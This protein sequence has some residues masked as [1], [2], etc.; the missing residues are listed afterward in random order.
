MNNW[1]RNEIIIKGPAD[2]L[3]LFLNEKL[4]FQKFHPRPDDEEYTDWNII[5]WGC[6][7]EPESIEIRLDGD[8]IKATFDTAWMPPTAF[9]TY[10]TEFYTSIKI[11]N[12]YMD[13]IC[14]FMGYSVSENGITCNESINPFDYSF[15][16]LREFAKTNL[17]YEPSIYE[18]MIHLSSDCFSICTCLNDEQKDDTYLNAHVIVDI[19]RE[20]YNEL[21]KRMT[22]LLT[23]ISSVC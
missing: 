12:K 23:G 9:L 18:N 10:L 6:K 4:K 20:S 16:V 21:V 11:E 8:H 19:S 5:H 1:V 13:E 2:T 7:C 17:W 14:A 15:K 22:L 3:A